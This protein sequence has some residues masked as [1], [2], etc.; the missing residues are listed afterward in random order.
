MA[1]YALSQRDQESVIGHEA[2][3]RISFVSIV[4]SLAVSFPQI[5]LLRRSQRTFYL[6]P[7]LVALADRMSVSLTTEPE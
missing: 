7:V 6:H 5:G 1:L 2:H 3:D 4:A